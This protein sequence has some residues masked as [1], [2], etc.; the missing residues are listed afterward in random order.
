MEE[1]ICQKFFQKG[2]MSED[3]EEI[4]IDF[5][6]RRGIE[7]NID[8]PKRKLCIR[9]LDKKLG[10]REKSKLFYRKA[11]EDEI[12]SR[13]DIILESEAYDPNKYGDLN[14]DTFLKIAM[15][16][17]DFTLLKLM[18]ISK[19]HANKFTDSFF[20]NYIVKHY[21]NL[22]KYRPLDKT[23]KQ[24]YLEIVIALNNLKKKYNYQYIDKDVN[25]VEKFKYV[26]MIRNAKLPEN[27]IQLYLLE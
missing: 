17:D 23:H 3:D 19:I 1:R 15:E 5:L 13:R 11:K 20:K 16:A 7:V 18:N 9:V 8:I 6:Y 12:L 24:Y 26:T 4:L 21:P 25:V 14:I 10:S 27:L 22:L 2:E